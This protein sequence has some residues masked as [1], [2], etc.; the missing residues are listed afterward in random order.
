MLNDQDIVS[1]INLRLAVLDQPIVPQQ[2]MGSIE[3]VVGPLVVRQRELF[4]RLDNQLCG[5][6]QRI[7]D[8]LDDYLSGTGRSPQLPRRTLILDEPGLA[9]ALSLPVDAD[10][11]RS[12]TISSYRLVNGIL[13]NPANDRRTTA[14]VF[15]IVEGGSPIP[16]DKLAVPVDVF[17][18]MLERAVTPP[19][20][21]LRLPW[22]SNQDQQAACFVS[23]HLRPIVVPAVPGFTDEVRM[24][25]RFFAPGGLVSNLD[26]VEGIFGN[27][28][29]PHLPEND[30]ALDPQGWTGTTGMVILAPHLTRVTKKELGLPHVKDATERQRRDG[31]CWA[32]EDELYNDGKAFK[33]CARDERG[34]IATI[35]A[36]NYFGYCKKEIKA[37]ISYSAN[38]FGL[39]EE[40]HSGGAN[41]YP[42]WNLSQEWTDTFT[43]D[44][45]TLEQVLERDPDSWQLQAEGHA[46]STIQPDLILVPAGATYSMRTQTITW[47]RGEGDQATLPLRAGV[48]YLTPCGY[49][50]H[51]KPREA[52]PTY[53][54]LIGTSPDATQ[55]HKPATVSGGG[56]SEISKSL[57]D[58]FTYGSAWT[59]D[60]EPDMDQV[61]ALLDHDYSDRFADPDHAP[62]NRPLLSDERSLGSVIKLL[63]PSPDFTDQYNQWLGTLPAHIIE[64][65]YTVKRFHRPE[66][67]QDWRSHFSVGHVNGRMS[68]SLRLDGDKIQVNMLRVGFEE[69]GSW[70]LF[71]LRPDFSPAAK[72][73]TE[74][75]ITASV[76]APPP[77]GSGR[78]S[79][80]DKYVK[81]CELLLFQRPDDAIH[82]GYDKQTERD[83]AR[84]SS[85]I[86]NFEPLTHA[87][88]RAIVEDA[89]GFSRFTEPMQALIREFAEQD[90]DSRPRYIAISSEPRLVDGKRSKNPRYLQVRP[91]LTNPVLTRATS[92]ASHL[93]QREPFG[94]DLRMPVHIVAAGR[95]NNAAEPGIPPFCAYNPL[96]Y[97]ELPELFME[98]ISS[99]TGK[100]P[101]TTGA[102]S[103]GAMTKGPF[104]P[105]P[106]II[107]LNAALLSYALTET[108]G[109][110]SSAGVIG[111]KVRVDHDISLL[112]P[113]L[114]S[115][116]SREERRG[117]A[118]V[119]GGYLERLEDYEHNG[120][121]VQASRLGYRMNALFASRY[122]GRIFLHPDV[123]FTEQMLRP[124]LQDL[125]AFT[126]SVKVIVTTHQRV[127][128][129]YFDDG[130]ISLA[131]P[132]LRA[133][134][135]IMAHGQSS[136]GWTLET[137][138][139]RALFQREAILASGWYAQRL[140]AKQSFDVARLKASLKKLKDF[141][142]E[143]SNA[144]AAARMGMAERVDA[145]SARLAFVSSPDYLASLEGTLG[146][147]VN[148]S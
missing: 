79:L 55:F 86:S 66:W 118:L 90:E 61:Q 53:W 20:E 5:V 22:T 94:S 98:F 32:S 112:V 25:T 83:M 17:A 120:E 60:F 51:A 40:E 127:S 72:V 24:E 34:V 117:S 68:N 9:R 133:L 106:A 21:A 64:L 104:N 77:E 136:E 45:Y 107:D 135:E 145:L 87:D 27:A 110:L 139:F 129:A 122:F 12:E 101:S 103:E 8:F 99:M 19:P 67:G 65:V 130:T 109:W 121:L 93:W 144:E 96:H 126:E 78:G 7:Q 15:H 2:D 141:V 88:A 97:M 4:R 114:F 41:A 105:L 71:S 143:P 70:R 30:A 140:G 138:A 33:L 46:I 1:A 134:L 49:R 125:D 54:H 123:V 3:G 13:H 39:A 56:K 47:Q 74:D 92:F 57:L 82:R 11:Y 119:E 44:G 58:A 28:G 73:Q 84:S 115:R 76:V 146:R 85:F 111:P 43:P 80:A 38:L 148:L 26:F 35:L 132:P 100:S 36:D 137:P 69:D 91:D 62:D 128:K 37:Q 116:M 59:Q 10:E 50:V 108:D 6:D 31:M 81:N 124:E 42:A 142:K 14:G 18:Q 75:D 113:E 89:P 16:D 147:Q 52:D 95:R 63:T 29:D 48:H 23:L 102:G 131:T